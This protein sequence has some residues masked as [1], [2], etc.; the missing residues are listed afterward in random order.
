MV[1]TK[2]FS[3]IIPVFAGIAMIVA[4]CDKAQTTPDSEP[5]P[6]PEVEEVQ[7]FTVTMTDIT[8]NTGVLNITRDDPD[9]PF[10]YSIMKWSDLEK[11]G[12]DFQTQAAAYM[13]GEYEF[14]INNFGY[15]AEEAVL[16]LAKTEDIKDLTLMWFSAATDY[17]LI[18]AYVDNNVKAVSKFECYEFS[19]LTPEPAN[20]T[21]DLK[22]TDIQK[23]S[24]SYT[25]TPSNREDTYALA[26]VKYEDYKDMTDEE[27]LAA[28][29]PNYSW[30]MYSGTYS[31]TESLLAG[32]EYMLAVYGNVYGA[33]TTKLYKKVFSTIDAGD[34]AACTFTTSYTD[35]SIKGY[36]ICATVTP[37]DD[38]I[39][40]FVE[41]VSEEYTAAQFMK[42]FKAN[43]DYMLENSG[44]PKDL[45]FEYYT[46]H[47]NYTGN[48]TVTPGQ[49]YKFAI[50]PV[51]S[52]TLEFASDVIFSDVMKTSTPE[53]SDVTV[54][55]SW[56]KYYDGDSI[57][58]YNSGYSFYQGVCVFPI[59]VN[60]SEG[61]AQIRY[62]V[63]VDNGTEYSKSEI[64][65]ALLENGSA[66]VSDCY[67]PFGRDGIVYAVAIDNNGLCG[68]IF[69]KKFNF[70]K[71]N[72]G[73][74][75]E[76][77]KDM[78]YAAPAKPEAKSAS[79]APARKFA[80]QYGIG[81]QAFAPRAAKQ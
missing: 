73:T 57:Y 41:F 64:V 66:W 17:V 18:V 58:E 55:V 70:S 11:L 43:M 2:F 59:T 23:R 65:Y 30:T 12:D 27:I 24:A 53:E 26:V 49:G 50:I 9:T 71:D 56:D 54:E 13:S 14:L 20:V 47:G 3:R 51:N 19:T 37:S 69:S 38:S 74:G 34:P 36:Q 77:F 44:L 48:Y 1:N 21:F 15:T 80:V 60:R 61:T 16:D 7:H 79:A 28:L 10:Y 45:Y 81:P 29:L 4:G 46:E 22:M 52:K 75:E 72:A 25:V 35:G 40:Y 62:G 32:T 63:F 6:E 8:Y 31:Q 78:G 39:D 33:A 67:A 68:P 76:Y 5:E 42:E